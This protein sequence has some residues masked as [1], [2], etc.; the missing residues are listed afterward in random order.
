MTTTSEPKNFYP[1]M[2]P[3]LEGETTVLYHTR[4]CSS[5]LVE[6]PYNHS[7][8]WNCALGNH[9]QCTST[10]AFCHCPCH[11][12]PLQ[13]LEASDTRIDD[14]LSQADTIVKDLLRAPAHYTQGSLECIDATKAMMTPDEW[15]GYCR[16]QAVAYIWRAPHKEDYDGDLKKAVNWL[17]MAVGDDFREDETDAR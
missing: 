1:D 9:A 12:S 14:L 10:E 15:S 16:G 7:R 4:L 13:T 11:D 3:R 8:W 6:N 17:R 2:P 5:L